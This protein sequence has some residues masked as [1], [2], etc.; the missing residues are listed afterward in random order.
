MSDEFN[1]EQFNFE[2][3]ECQDTPLGLVTLPPI[4]G[5]EG[6]PPSCPCGW[7]P[8]GI[9]QTN[10]LGIYVA[11]WPAWVISTNPVIYV[12]HTHPTCMTWYDYNTHPFINSIPMNP[13]WQEY[14]TMPFCIDQANG[15]NWHGAFP[16]LSAIGAGWANCRLAS[17]LQAMTNQQRQDIFNNTYT[18]YG[19]NGWTNPSHTLGV[20]P[21]TP[22]MAWVPV[23]VMDTFGLPSNQPNPLPPHQNGGWAV[24]AMRWIK[25]DAT[26][27][28][29]PVACF[30]EN[31]ACPNTCLGCTDL[32]STT[33]IT[34][35]GACQAYDPTTSYFWPDLSSY[36]VVGWPSASTLCCISGCT[37]PGDPNY[38]PLA[39][40]DDGSCF[41]GGPIYG[42][43]DPNAVIC[44]S[45]PAC[46]A[47]DSAATIDDGTCCIQG[48]TNSNAT[49]YNTLANC[50]D[51]SC[52]Y[53]PVPG[54]MDSNAI[55]YMDCC[56]LTIPGCVPTIQYDACCKYE[57][58]EIYCDCCK[59]G[60]PVTWATPV[61]ATPG[62]SV[63]N[64]TTLT[65][66]TPT[67]TL[68]PEDCETHEL[69]EE[70]QKNVFTKETIEYDKKIS[71]DTRGGVYFTP[72]G[73]EWSGP[74]HR[75]P[76]GM[77]MSGNPHDIDGSGSEGRSEI[78]TEIYTV[79]LTP[80]GKQWCGDMHE[81]MLGTIMS[82]KERNVWG[83]GP[84]GKSELLSK[85]TLKNTLS[86]YKSCKTDEPKPSWDCTSIGCMLLPP[87]WPY[88]QFT[89]P[90]AYMDCW[91]Q[92]RS[93]KCGDLSLNWPWNLDVCICYPTYGTGASQ[94]YPT[95]ALCLSATT[96][97]PCCT[98]DYNTYNCTINGCEV[99]IGPGFGTYSQS[100]YAL[101]ECQQDCIAWGCHDVLMTSA[102]TTT[103]LSYTDFSFSTPHMSAQTANTVV[104]TS[105]ITTTTAI[106]D[107]DTCIHVYYDAS[108]MGAQFSD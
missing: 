61:P 7:G 76:G 58:I 56:D 55:N 62:C 8:N 93:W 10:S 96:T 75:M 46:S 45:N 50:D 34:N 28:M 72:S 39:T 29:D 49:N 63:L 77:L 97:D 84:D 81:S 54:C 52:V 106:S 30:L 37:T 86:E 79:Y 95:Q 103:G 99:H 36:P 85:N 74:T 87:L 48:C 107:G 16:S 1:F 5:A 70:G 17:D 100:P 15:N 91:T 73:E 88:G 80:S 40:C 27:S 71:E 14:L 6:G 47:Y 82:G 69:K 89:G 60:Y 42:C 31:L 65:H 4:S 32:T 105:A 104:W 101:W 23:F 35:P 20:H 90:N 12:E 43:M 2:P 24:P 41:Y 38:N 25:I 67:G 26:G 78:L 83:S 102:Y 108:S 22:P 9:P 3:G 94:T 68:P 21:G 18:A 64:S 11:T 53:P 13:C 66:C 57:P 51:G 19:P 92:C 33:C 59:G 98:D 44:S